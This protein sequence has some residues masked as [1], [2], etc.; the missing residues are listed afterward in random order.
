MSQMDVIYRVNGANDAVAAMQR[1]NDTTVT[2]QLQKCANR[3]CEHGL[4]LSLW[5]FIH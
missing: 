5:R 4:T 3:L 2:E 1:C